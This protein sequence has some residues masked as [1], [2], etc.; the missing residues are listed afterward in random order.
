M[1]AIGFTGF[2]IHLRK[3]WSMLHIPNREPTMLLLRLLFNGHTIAPNSSHTRV[4]NPP[5]AQL[6]QNRRNL[7]LQGRQPGGDAW[8]AISKTGL[9]SWVYKVWGL[10]GLGFRV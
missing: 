8:F 1:E 5:A 7:W 4:E 6:L 10:G 2:A 3:P 9:G